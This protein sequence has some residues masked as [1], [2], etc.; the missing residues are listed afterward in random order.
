MTRKNDATDALTKSEKGALASCE[1][2]IE[3]GITS[4]VE[5]G[6]ALTQIRDAKLY[7]AT[8]KTFDAYCKDRWEI[9]RSRAYELIDQA[10]VT[11]TLAEVGVDLSAAADISKRDAR[12]LKDDPEAVAQIKQRV[13]S[14]EPAAIVVKAVAADKRAERDNRQAEN[15]ALQEQTRAALPGAI[16]RGEE[17]RARNGSTQAA[18]AGK[19][20]L[21]QGIEEAVLAERDELLE[22]NAALKAD[23][24][25]R[26]RRLALFDDMA[27]QF[28]KGGFEAVIATKDE[29][30]R[31][32]RAQVE[33][34]SA[35]KAAWVR[36]A[37]YWKKQAMALGFAPPDRQ[38]AVAADL[39]V[40]TDL[41]PF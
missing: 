7:R 27:V 32:L 29:Q 16:R 18:V 13:S 38:T 3:R 33:S 35:D 41:A 15:D 28:E 21:I 31:V 10:K 30:I 23:I 2:I 22:E 26:D 6:K 17:A 40:D 1:A 20:Q 11:T 37:A 39:D 8:H 19:S 34:E 25:D 4:F 9:G 24:A 12:V 14:G 5:V 36:K